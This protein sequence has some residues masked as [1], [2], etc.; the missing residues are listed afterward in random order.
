LG[1]YYVQKIGWNLMGDEFME[2]YKEVE[3]DRLSIW[4]IFEH[5][6]CIIKT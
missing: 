4:M 3:Q 5:G 6:I 1:E 2:S